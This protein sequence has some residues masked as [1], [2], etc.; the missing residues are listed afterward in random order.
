MKRK[1]QTVLFNLIVV[2]G[3]L[4]LGGCNDS[5]GPGNES[6]RTVLVLGDSISAD[7]TYPGAIP[8]PELMRGMRPE[9][10]IVNSSRGGDQSSVGASKVN[11]LVNSVQPNALVI[12]YGANDA[13]NGNHLSYESNLRTMIAAGQRVGAE[14]VVCTTP[15]MYGSRSIYDFR[16]D[17]I[18][19]TA[20]R[21]ASETGARVADIYGEFGQSSSDLFPDG[22]HPNLDGQRIIAVSVVEK[23]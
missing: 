7:E 12:F 13:I 11:G 16:V 20:K 3:L 15:Y 23:I 14:V 9:W 2:C 22:L 1:L 5:G 21:V 18:R 10:N 6:A 19:E 17:I 4:M 8:W